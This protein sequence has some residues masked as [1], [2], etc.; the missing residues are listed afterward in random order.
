MLGEHI[1]TTVDWRGL[2]LHASGPHQDGVARHSGWSRARPPVATR[3]EQMYDFFVARQGIA[4][5]VKRV[6]T[7]AAEVIVEPPAQLPDG[8]PPKP[9]PSQINWEPTEDLQ[10]DAG[11]EHSL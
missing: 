5:A 9:P 11:I 7:I 4:H 2:Q 6:A 3:N 1:R 8:P 10:S